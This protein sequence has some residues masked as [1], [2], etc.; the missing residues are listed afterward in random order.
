MKRLISSLLLLVIC[1]GCNP[2]ITTGVTRISG[3]TFVLK[4]GDSEIQILTQVPT[5][6]KYEEIA[7]LNATTDTDS[8]TRKAF[9][10]MLP[11]LKAKACG[12]GANG[13]VIKNVDQGGQW[14][15]PGGKSAAQTPTKAFCV[16]ILITKL[17]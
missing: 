13:I 10:L 2:R 1:L 12:L 17:K 14:A 15:E 7:I 6:R 5:D 4:P 11:S 8:V 3:E 9:N 16:A